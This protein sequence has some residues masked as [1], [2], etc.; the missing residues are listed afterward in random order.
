[1]TTATSRN[2]SEK[3]DFIRMPINAEA[4]IQLADET[5][6]RRCVCHN[7]SAAGMLLEINRSLPAG[8]VF[9]A[10][11]PSQTPGFK[12][13]TARVSVTRCIEYGDRFLIGVHIDE[14]T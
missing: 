14:L 3:R 6:E 10:E 9:M 4:V 1:M 11:L 5:E 2:Y 12:A 13:L 7:L 8:T